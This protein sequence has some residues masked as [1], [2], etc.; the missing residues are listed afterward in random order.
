MPKDHIFEKEESKGIEAFSLLRNCNVVKLR[1]QNFE[2]F[3][4]Q[5][6]FK[7]CIHFIFR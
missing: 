1:H 3:T 4:L 6:P 5:S 7:I 2:Y